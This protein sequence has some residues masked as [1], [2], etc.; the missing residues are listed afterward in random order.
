MI[1]DM[2]LIQSIMFD[3]GIEKTIDWYLKN[4]EWMQKVVSGEYARFYNKNYEI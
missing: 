3:N 1:E 4:T 2:E